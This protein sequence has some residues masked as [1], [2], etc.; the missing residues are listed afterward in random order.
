MERQA[1][2]TPTSTGL[3]PLPHLPLSTHADRRKHHDRDVENPAEHADWLKEKMDAASTSGKSQDGSSVHEKRSTSPERSTMIP[4]EVSSHAVV[5]S[6]S[7]E[8]V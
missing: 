2:T 1:T 7:V 5:A 6:K 8:Q 4:M 3:S